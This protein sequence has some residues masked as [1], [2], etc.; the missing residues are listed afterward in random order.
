MKSDATKEQISNIKI[1]HFYLIHDGSPTGHPGYVIWKDDAKNLYLVIR[2]DSY[3][4]GETTKEERRVRHITKLKYP[5]SST[6]VNSYVKN[7]PTMCKRK[8]IG[9]KPFADI[10]FHKDD[11][12]TIKEIS[13]RKPEYSRSFK[14]KK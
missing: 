11:M 5:T 7:R 12:E 10:A 14:N 6:V 3:K 1:G 13:K 4:P 9:K 2:L 8:D